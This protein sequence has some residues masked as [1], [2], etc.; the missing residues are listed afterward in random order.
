MTKRLKIAAIGCGARAVT[1]LSEAVRDMSALYEVVAGADPVESAINTIREIS[2]NPNFRSFDSA[3]ALL[4]EDKLADVLLISTQDHMHYQPCI[5]AMEKGYD[6]LLEKPIATDLAEIIEMERIAKRLNRRV[7]L[8]HIYRFSPFYSKIKEIIDSG[9]LGDIVSIN[10][11][12]GVGQW[13]QSHSF[14]RGKWA[15][16][17][18]A[19]PMILA[20]CCHDMDYLSWLIDEDCVEVSSFGNLSHFNQT[21]KPNGAPERCT[22]GCPVASSCHYNATRYATDKRHPWLPQ[23]MPNEKNSSTDEILQWLKVSPWGRCVYQ[24]DNDV[25]D[26]QVVAMKFK[27]NITC[28]FTMTAFDNGRSID[29][30][31]TK[32]RLK[33]GEFL[34]QNCGFDLSVVEHAS[35]AQTR[36]DFKFDD[37]AYIHHEGGDSG[38]VKAIYSEMQDPEPEKMRA[39]ISRAIQSHLM[40]FAAE[41]SR[42]CGKTINIG[43]MIHEV[44]NNDGVI[45]EY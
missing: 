1:Y 19:T 34:S 31:G 37:D 42:L 32:G 44:T 33:G 40:S 8:C 38:L 36:Y 6:I 45:N 16:T 43:K 26:H 13:H 7:M 30:Y 35:D 5:Q 12:E 22:D 28:T 24:C 18:R 27:K 14:V 41:K 20:K 4:A 11:S 2:K 23:I 10:A 17:E 39:S 25:V 15:I 21:N 9:V 29:I 3:D